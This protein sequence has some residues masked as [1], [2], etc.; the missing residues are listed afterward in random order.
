MSSGQGDDADKKQNQQQRQGAVPKTRI[1][2]VPLAERPP[3]G[4]P[5]YQDPANQFQTWTGR[6]KR[7]NWLKQYLEA[8]RSLEE[9]KI[10]EQE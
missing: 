3:V 8:G 5:R 7:P 2:F 9:F 10:P 4:K 1:E 6:G